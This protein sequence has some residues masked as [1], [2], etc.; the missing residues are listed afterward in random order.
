MPIEYGFTLNDPCPTLP[1]I[2]YFFVFSNVI[3]ILRKPKGLKSTQNLNY[4][5]T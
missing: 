5:A 3:N 2:S 1:I 4:L